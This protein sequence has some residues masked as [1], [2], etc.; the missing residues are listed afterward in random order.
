[1]TSVRAKL[2][3]ETHLREPLAAELIAAACRLSVR[4]L[5]RLFEREETSLMHYVWERR[6]ARSRAALR[7]PAMRHRH[8]GDIAFAAG[9]ND[10][11]HF[12][13]AYRG[14][15]GCTATATRISQFAAQARRCR[16]AC[17]GGFPRLARR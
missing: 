11:A 2:W 7:D 16:Q 14:P 15:Y 10:L 3:I 1:M 17:G 12:N 4:Y 13:R 9:F 5:N 8:I 6:L